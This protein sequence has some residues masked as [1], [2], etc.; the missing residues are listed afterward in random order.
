M[1]IPTL[2]ILLGFITTFAGIV[3]LVVELIKARS[4][5]PA[6]YTILAGISLVFFSLTFN[7]DGSFSWAGLLILSILAFTI[8]LFMLVIALIR[9]K[10]K[11]KAL[12]TLLISFAAIVV[13]FVMTPSETSNSARDNAS[14]DLAAKQTA[15]EPSATAETPQPTPT[16]SPKPTVPTVNPSP[17][18]AEQ[19]I[20]RE[21][22]ASHATWAT[23]K[24]LLRYPDN[25][26]GSYVVVEVKIS[27]IIETG[28][29]LFPGKTYY[30][31][32]TDNDGYGWYLDDEYCFTDDRL[33]GNMKILEDD[34]IIVYGQF[35]GLKEF[36]R[37]L[38][39]T[40]D[41]FPVISILYLYFII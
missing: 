22:I 27:Q 8:G 15:T 32:Y 33:E 2:F 30:R 41:E 21:Y 14:T 35:T 26:V 19:E 6:L 4:K 11:K 39:K 7:S 31:G 40:T 38:T 1:D 3:M 29:I 12:Y 13:A 18:Q 28:G 9:K 34:K 37:A 36:T 16:P 17:A 20:T 10:P 23:Y 24:D 25:Y 5:R